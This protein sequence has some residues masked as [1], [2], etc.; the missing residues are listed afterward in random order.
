MPFVYRLTVPK[1]ADNEIQQH[2]YWWFGRC[3]SQS[4]N[5]REQ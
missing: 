2:E 1:T 3:S 5:N 4:F